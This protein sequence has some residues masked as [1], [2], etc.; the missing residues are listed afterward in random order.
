MSLTKPFHIRIVTVTNRDKKIIPLGLHVKTKHTIQP[1]PNIIS[2]LIVVSQRHEPST[3]GEID[4]M[5][6]CFKA[7]SR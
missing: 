6:H 2:N 4:A 3:R 1:K 7:T 5:N